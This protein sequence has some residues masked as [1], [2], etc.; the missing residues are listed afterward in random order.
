MDMPLRRARP[1]SGALK[2]AAVGASAAGDVQLLAPPPAPVS[3]AAGR[4]R[5]EP[6]R[7]GQAVDPEAIAN[8][9]YKLM[10][11]ELIIARERE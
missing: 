3:L 11:Q 10:R 9:V 8:R 4:E 7:A 2:G 5:E 6:H 1:R